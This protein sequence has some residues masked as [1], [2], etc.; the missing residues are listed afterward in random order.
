MIPLQAGLVGR[1][2]RVHLWGTT[3]PYRRLAF[4]FGALGNLWTVSQGYRIRRLV[5]ETGPGVRL[6]PAGPPS[7]FRSWIRSVT[8]RGCHSI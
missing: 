3:T 6:P 5:P 8:L 2:L 4:P 7:R 1:P